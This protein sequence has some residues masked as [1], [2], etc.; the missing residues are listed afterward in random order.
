SIEYQALV[1]FYNAMGGSSWNN[2]WDINENNLNEGAWT[3]LS[4]E[5]GHVTGLNL[6]NT[7]NVSGS[8][9]ASF[10]NLKYLKNLSLYA[11]SYSKNLST[12]DLNVISELQSLETLDMRYCKIE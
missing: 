10:G 8:I 7:S 6:N 9:P 2:K 12:T 4:I 3:G 11:G 5:N 1:D